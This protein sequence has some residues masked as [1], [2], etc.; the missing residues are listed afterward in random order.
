[1]IPVSRRAQNAATA[2]SPYG[3]G[4][5]KGVYEKKTPQKCPP[6]HVSSYS[7]V[8]PFC[9]LLALHSVR[10][11]LHCSFSLFCSFILFFFCCFFL[12]QGPQNHN[13][14]LSRGSLFLYYVLI[15]SFPPLCTVF[16][17]NFWKKKEKKRQSKRTSFLLWLI[18]VTP[19]LTHW[20]VWP[21]IPSKNVSVM[22]NF[23][24]IFR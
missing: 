5:V 17:S 7:K 3:Q 8:H 12:L 9:C 18:Y 15:K 24:T 6:P 2:W 1:M 22:K 4:G 23:S 13:R 11:F 14:C 21:S 16:C 10:F 20:F 19:F